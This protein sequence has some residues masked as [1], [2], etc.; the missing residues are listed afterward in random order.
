MSGCPKTYDR[1]G[2]ALLPGSRVVYAEGEDSPIG[3]VV[4]ISDPDID[5]EVGLIAPDVSV[6]WPGEDGTVEHSTS[7]E[8]G[9]YDRATRDGDEPYFICDDLRAAEAEQPLTADDLRRM[10]EATDSA[11]LAREAGA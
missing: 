9:W 10:F 2:R 7:G 8:G 1:D 3:T 6:A 11:R 5:E 4:A